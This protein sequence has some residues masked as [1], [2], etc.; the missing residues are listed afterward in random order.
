MV[1][2]KGVHIESG[3]FIYDFKRSLSMKIWMPTFSPIVRCF[4]PM[5][6]I[7]PQSTAY[8][9]EPHIGLSLL[10]LSNSILCYQVVV[11]LVC[12]SKQPENTLSFILLIKTQM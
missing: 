7:F 5:V 8:L 10:T 6:G 1:N 12:F 4:I 2:G 9:N 11:V 3:Y